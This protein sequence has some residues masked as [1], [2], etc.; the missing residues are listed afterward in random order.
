[1]AAATGADI[2]IA[3]WRCVRLF[4]WM[5]DWGDDASYVLQ[6]LLE[7][8]RP[9]TAMHC[10]RFDLE[11]TDARLLHELLTGFLQGEESEGPLPESWDIQEV[12]ERLERSGDI[13]KAALIQLEFML[14]PAL[15]YAKESRAE[16]RKSAPAARRSPHRK[17]PDWTIRSA[18]IARA[19]LIDFNNQLDDGD[20]D[21]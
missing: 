21:N 7:V 2:D 16:T 13:E 6:R 15:H 19:Y 10:C 4:G 14:F 20:C 5:R 11:Q 8:R 1:L 17:K 9:R 3:Y 18:P 12:L